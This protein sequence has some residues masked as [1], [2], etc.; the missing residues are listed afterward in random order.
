VGRRRRGAMIK[1]G[2]PHRLRTRSWLGGL[3]RLTGSWVEGRAGRI[4]ITGS[5]ASQPAA[6]ERAASGAEHPLWVVC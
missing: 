2:R 5:G 4:T 1:F 3:V 6:S